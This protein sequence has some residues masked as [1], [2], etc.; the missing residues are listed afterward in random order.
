[1]SVNFEL[2]EQE[3][4]GGLVCGFSFASSRPKVL[5]RTPTKVLLLIPGYSSYV[6]SIG[7]THLYAP[8]A[9][10][11]FARQEDGWRHSSKIA[12]GGRFTD[13]RLRELSADI[14]KAMGEEGL[15]QLLDVKKTL[16]LGQ[17]EPFHG[18]REGYAGPLKLGWTK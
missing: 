5:C 9:L 17:C 4:T 3:R 15:A 16:V 18:H 7:T 8:T 1:M 2:V 11:K 10:W 13:A 6:C 12:E 14:D